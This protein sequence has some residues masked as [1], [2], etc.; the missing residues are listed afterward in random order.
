MHSR[1]MTVVAAVTAAGLLSILVISQ[2]TH[3]II[4]GDPAVYRERIEALLVGGLPYRDVPFEQLPMMLVPMGLAW[5]LGGSASQ[6]AYV[7]VF[8]LLMVLTMAATT[9]LVARL[10]SALDERSAAGRWL[11]I[12]VP[13]MPLAVFRSDPFVVLH[14]AGALLAFLQAKGR[15]TVLSILGALAKIWPAVLA[16]L[17]WKRG[18][19]VGAVAVGLGGVLAFGI[20]LLPGFTEARSAVGIHAETVVGGLLGLARVAGGGAS[21]VDVTTAAY[22][23]VGSWAVAVNAAIG[24]AVLAIGLVSVLRAAADREAVLGVGVLII[25]A[26]LVSPLFSLQYVLWIMPV[27]ALS[28]LRP[29]VASGVGLAVLTTALAWVWS[30]PILE[31]VWFYAAVTVRNVMVLVIAGLLLLESGLS[32]RSEPAARIP[33]SS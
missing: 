17:G 3:T 27:V 14:F 29:T 6:S 31:S 18:R 8:A 22:L 23:P 26:I 20:T 10:G 11:L 28:R 1:R 25:G 19:Q 12:T 9:V 13:L 30:E 21:Q 33:V 16:A 5:V 24:L 4:P 7:F 15:W 32:S 2:A